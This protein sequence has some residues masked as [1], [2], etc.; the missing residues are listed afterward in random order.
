MPRCY[1]HLTTGGETLNDDEGSDLIDVEAAREEGLK[2]ARE[3]LSISLVASGQLDLTQ[4]I[5]IADEAGR[6][7]LVI[8]FRSAVSVE[9]PVERGSLRLS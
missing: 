2:A 7:L 8:P 1:F 6:T 3:I 5:D 9:V 4:Q